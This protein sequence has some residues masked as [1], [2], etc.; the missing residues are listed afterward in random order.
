MKWLWH[1]MG[2][3]ASLCLISAELK[4]VYAISLIVIPMELYWYWLLIFSWAGRKTKSA[5]ERLNWYPRKW[6]RV[7]AKFKCTATN[8]RWFGRIPLQRFYAVRLYVPEGV[9]HIATVAS[10]V[11]CACIFTMHTATHTHRIVITI[12]CILAS[13]MYSSFVANPCDIKHSSSRL[14]DW[15]FR[16]TGNPRTWYG[17]GKSSAAV[18]WHR[19]V[20]LTIQRTISL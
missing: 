5:R 2:W 19:D 6:C 1:R 12:N 13:N 3:V 7:Y 18:V 11:T 10:H 20:G 15:C 17:Y 4:Y 8:Q 14:L 16:R 9:L